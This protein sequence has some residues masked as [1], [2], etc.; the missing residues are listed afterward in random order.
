ME[1]KIHFKK[2]LFGLRV[3]RVTAFL[4]LGCD[5]SRMGDG[6]C[7]DDLNDEKCNFDMGDCCPHMGQSTAFHS[8]EQAQVLAMKMITYVLLQI[9]FS[10]LCQHK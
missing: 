7:D 1:V 6:F 5:E 9:L 8:W 3:S 10:V 2:M 4:D